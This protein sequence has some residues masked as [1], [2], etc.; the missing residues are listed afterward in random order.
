MHV[1]PEGGVAALDDAD[2]AGERVVHGRQAE[3]GPRAALVGAA[4]LDDEGLEHLGAEPLVVAQE[5]AQPPRQRADPLADRHLGD[6]LSG[7]VQRG[8]RHAA[9]ETRGAEASASAGKGDEVLEPTSLAANADAAVLEQTAAQVLLD[10]A[11]HEGRQSASRLGT[12][13]ELAPVRRDRAVEHRLP[14]TMT[15]VRA[16]TSRV[17]AWGVPS[18]DRTG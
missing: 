2:G 15:L 8:V 5:H 17:A 1:E 4:Q 13:L 12:L 9:A 3:E 11:H 7:E 16:A 14:G 18:H 10:L 6:D